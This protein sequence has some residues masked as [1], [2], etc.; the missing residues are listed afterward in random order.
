MLD[1]ALQA[2]LQRLESAEDRPLRDLKSCPE[3]TGVYTLWDEKGQSGKQ[4]LLYVGT[5]RVDPRKTKNPDARG[6]RGRLS[7]YLENRL[8][9]DFTRYIFLR[10]IVPELSSDDR[11]KLGAGEMGVKEMSER[12]C[13]WVEK[14]VSYRALTCDAQTARQI[15]SHVCRSGLPNAGIPV[16]N[17]RH[18]Q[19]RGLAG[20]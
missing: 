20:A 8:D 7:G 18:R 19:P 15:E 16:L 1:S 12:V 13:S 4:I 9:N 2:D 10:F 11:A 3:T 14:R 6:I 5:V 17:P